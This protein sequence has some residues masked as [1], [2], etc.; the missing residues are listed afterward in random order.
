MEE[1]TKNTDLKWSL[2]LVKKNPKKLMV[3]EVLIIKRWE[4]QEPHENLSRDNRCL[5]AFLNCYPGIIHVF[6]RYK[7]KIQDNGGA[8][9]E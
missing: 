3:C 1:E 2:S 4:V 7:A 5:L 6:I 9:K 8:R